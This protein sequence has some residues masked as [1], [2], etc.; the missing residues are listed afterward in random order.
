MDV[1][2]EEALLIKNSDE[3]MDIL[4]NMAFNNYQWPAERTIMKRVVV[5]S[6]SNPIDLLPTQLAF[7]TNDLKEIKGMDQLKIRPI[8]G[9]QVV[10]EDANFVNN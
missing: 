5:T 6:S 9:E 1:V 8:S 10:M 2:V 3:A 4:E 7:L